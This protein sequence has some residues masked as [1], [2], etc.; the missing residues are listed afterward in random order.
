MIGY[1]PQRFSL[2]PDLTVGRIYAF[3]RTCSR[4]PGPSGSPA[5]MICWR[6]PGSHPLWTAGRCPFRRHETKTGPFLRPGAYPRVLVLDEPTT[7]VDPV[8]RREFWAILGKLKQD[9]T[10]ILVS[11][12]YM[13]EAAQ[14]D[15]IAL[16]HRGNILVT[17]TAPEIARG[18]S[19]M[20]YAIRA[21]DSVRAANWFKK[22][23]DPSRFALFE[24]MS[25][26][27]FLV[28]TT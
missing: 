16:M 21:A 23:L 10:T 20:V 8:S 2:Y 3:S 18:F 5:L 11:T 6:F 4:F 19:G 15:R 17:G 14:C 22:K 25:G 1:M 7:G 12:P 27:V 9:G 24:T 13:D 28:M 26:S